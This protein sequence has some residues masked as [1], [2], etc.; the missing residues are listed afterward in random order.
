MQESQHIE[1]KKVDNTLSTFICTLIPIADNYA[2]QTREQR[3]SRKPSR[4]CNKLAKS[5][6]IH[7]ESDTLI[8]SLH[9][10]EESSSMSHAT[11]VHISL[12]HIYQTAKSLISKKQMKNSTTSLLNINVQPIRKRMTSTRPSTLFVPISAHATK[13]QVYSASSQP[14]LNT[15]PMASPVHSSRWINAN[16]SMPKVAYR[17]LRNVFS[18]WWMRKR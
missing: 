6:Q 13:A 4:N 7:Q 15:K 5:A 17:V 9:A 14:M 10:Q 1:V 12:I 3:M 8:Q 11:P 2:H 18:S 16:P